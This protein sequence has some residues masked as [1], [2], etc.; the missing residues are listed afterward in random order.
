MPVPRSDDHELDES[1]AGR[2]RQRKIPFGRV[3]AVH[4]VARVQHEIEHYLLQF[5]P[6]AEHERHRRRERAL[7]RDAARRQLAVGE[8]DDFASHI[9][10]VDRLAR[11]VF[12]PQHGAEAIDHRAGS[13]VVPDDVVERRPQQL[14]VQ[15][16]TIEEAPR[17]LRVAED[18]RQ[19]LAQLVRER[20]RQLA[21]HRDPAQVRQ[22]AP[23][24]AGFQLRAPPFGDVLDDAEDLVA[25]T[26]D[27]A[28]L[29]ESFV[30]FGSEGV[31]DLLR[32]V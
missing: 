11:D 17:G 6:I 31:L 15:W 16:L 13:F 4:G 9:V 20:A 12:L 10:D 1:A 28:C 22:L 5:H 27:D 23:L 25:V 18:G 30:V 14:H 2:R 24:R 7:D 3:R 8:I 21:Q 29:V 26:A 32:L 19:R